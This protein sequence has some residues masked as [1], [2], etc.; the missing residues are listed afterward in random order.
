MRKSF[1]K[2]IA[3]LMMAAGLVIGAPAGSNIF[4]QK[5][6][7]TVYAAET[8]VEETEAPGGGGGG[9]G[10]GGTDDTTV[11]PGGGGGGGGGGGIDIF[12]FLFF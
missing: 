8:D 6:S 7:G 3:L 10:G 5:N 12:I 4:G 1:S 2:N 9:G 11:T